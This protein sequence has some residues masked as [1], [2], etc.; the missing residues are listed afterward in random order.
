MANGTLQLM[1]KQSD[2][3]DAVGT[4]MWVCKVSGVFSFLFFWRNITL[5]V[6]THIYVLE[7]RL[8]IRNIFELGSSIVTIFGV[9]FQHNKC[10]LS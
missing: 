2:G 7:L 1:W 4:N 8:I 6:Y 9:E 10:V 5:C 3:R